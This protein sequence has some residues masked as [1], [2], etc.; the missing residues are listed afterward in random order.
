MQWQ[1]SG[2][3]FE[4]AINENSSAEIM[5]R[6]RK[7]YFLFRVVLRGKCGSIRSAQARVEA[8]VD[9]LGLVQG[10]G[11]NEAAVSDTGA[12]EGAA[13]IQL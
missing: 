4:A 3:G 10:A 13:D 1:P 5:S 2:N 8:I 11:E 12:F 7:G 6:S 9:Q